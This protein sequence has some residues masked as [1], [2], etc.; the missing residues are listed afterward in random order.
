MKKSKKG[1]SIFLAVSMV[2]AMSVSAFA[3]EAPVEDVGALAV[4]GTTNLIEAGQ[5]DDGARYWVLQLSAG[6]SG[7]VAAAIAGASVM[8]SN[9]PDGAAYSWTGNV[10]VPVADG[11]GHN[12]KVVGCPF[13]AYP[14]Q[15]VAFGIE[16]STPSNI[17]TINV[18]F[19]YMN[20][21][22]SIWKGGL[23]ANQVVVFELM[24]S[25][26]EGEIRVSTS[27]NQSNN[28]DV[29]FYTSSTCPAYDFLREV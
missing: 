25:N 12:G 13:K 22:N 6:E 23:S 11:S 29:W 1:I 20:C 16:G 8:V 5:F 21:E 17:P 10:R 28:V 3:S 24:H 19:S 26:P 2:M 15:Y 18:S 27:E 14:D 9:L 7:A 4:D